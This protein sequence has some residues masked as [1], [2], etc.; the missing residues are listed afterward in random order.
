MQHPAHLASLHL[1]PELHFHIVVHYALW[2]YQ[3]VLRNVDKPAV[4]EI[5]VQAEE[6]WGKK[7]NC[8]IFA[9]E[10]ELR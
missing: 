6:G 1:R 9:S 10:E 8:Q 2:T 4:S 3:H 5:G 7:I